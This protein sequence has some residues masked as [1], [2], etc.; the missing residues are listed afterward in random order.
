MVGFASPFG[1]FPLVMN[2]LPLSNVRFHYDLIC[3]I[4]AFFELVLLIALQEFSTVL[5]HQSLTL[6]GRGNRELL[7]SYRD[8]LD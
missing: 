4:G 1:L 5:Y 8:F 6:R 7:F 2:P 3:E